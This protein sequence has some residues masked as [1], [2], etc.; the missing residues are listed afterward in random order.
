MNDHHDAAHL[1]RQTVEQP[2]AEPDS[3]HLAQVAVGRG[4]QLDG[5]AI[6]RLISAGLVRRPPQRL[7]GAPEFELTAEGLAHIRSS[8]Q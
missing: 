5:D 2:I 6:A 1:H 4:S 3:R 7:P 8:D